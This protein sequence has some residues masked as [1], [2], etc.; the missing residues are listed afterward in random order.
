MELNGPIVETV[1]ALRRVHKTKLPDAIIAATALRHDLTLV[2]R[3]THDFDGIG[4]N[5]YNPFA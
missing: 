3:N 5:T 2:T 1:I 4:I